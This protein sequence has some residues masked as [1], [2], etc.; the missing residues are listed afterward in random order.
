M[1]KT[2]SKDRK[3]KEKVKQPAAEK[4]TVKER[5]R[6]WLIDIPVIILGAVV[7]SAGINV[8]TAPN[9]IAPGGIGGLSTV[10]SHLSD[11]V[12]SIGLIF[13][14]I[15]IPLVIAGFI[16][17]G[18][19]MMTR[20]LLAVAVT[21]LCT[22]YFRYLFPVYE[23]DKIIAAVFGGVLIGFGLG[24]VY[25]RDGTTGGTDIINKLIQRAKPH[26]SLGFIMMMTDAMVVLI[27]ILVYGNF[28]SGLYAII[29][30]FVSSKVMDSLLYGTLEG[31]MA[32]IFSEKPDEIG[33]E[34]I[35]SLTRGA[36]FLKGNGV[37]SGDEKKVIC[38]A[39]HKNEYVKL[40]RKV[41]EIDPH[42]FI[43]ATTANEI[44]GE[45]FHKID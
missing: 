20:T 25:L 12:L 7:Y 16:R 37:Y 5:V 38:C 26:L 22:D 34:I 1:K 19:S 31:K 2:K 21:T 41:R 6:K 29:A 42:A 43:I 4:R 32:L 36:T 35:S 39:V 30:I 24:I 13:G 40:K 45:G 11:G 10:I 23:G 14:I 27:S 9:D 33:G 8:F 15:N 3:P 17:L 28:E 18:R 44:L